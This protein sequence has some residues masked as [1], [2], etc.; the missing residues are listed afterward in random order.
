MKINLTDQEVEQVINAIVKDIL[1]INTDGIYTIE[2][3]LE[4][5]IV[6]EVSYKIEF[7]KIPNAD[8]GDL[9]LNIEV[10]KG[11]IAIFDHYFEIDNLNKI[12]TLLKTTM[13]I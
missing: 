6:I 7:K 8:T 13:D 2:M 11:N 1:K 5:D 9:I 12:N 10:L 4:G 3:V